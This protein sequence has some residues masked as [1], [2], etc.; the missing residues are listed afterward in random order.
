MKPRAPE[1]DGVLKAY[2]ARQSVGVAATLRLLESSFGSA[3]VFGSHDAAEDNG[4][5]VFLA[6]L[7][8]VTGLHNAK[9]AN[10]PDL[11]EGLMS[12]KPVNTNDQLLERLLGKKDAR[13]HKKKQAKA[14]SEKGAAESAAPVAKP[15]V[16]RKAEVVAHESEDEEEG[17]GS[18]FRT[19]K[20]ARSAVKT[21]VTE[22]EAEVKPTSTG[23]MGAE[24][25]AQAPS[26]QAKEDAK[27]RKARPASYLDEL[28]AKKGRKKGTAR[29]KVSENG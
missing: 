9:D 19:K 8:D 26:K 1:S 15:V 18:S 22:A 29:G 28:L 27:A 17:R 21:N 11:P 20:L 25:D 3:P 7:G 12:G 2:T 5:K 23:V 4:T 13:E 16:K 24:E 6:S 10:D 14:K